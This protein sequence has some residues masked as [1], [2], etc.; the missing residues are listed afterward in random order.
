M[1]GKSTVSHLNAAGVYGEAAGTGTGVYGTSVYT[2]VYGVST[3]TSNGSGG[4]FVSKGDFGSGI[5]GISEGAN[6]YGVRGDGGDADFYA[7]GPGTNYAAASSVRWKSNIVEIDG[8]L[9]MV[10]NMRGV[11]Y[12]WDEEHGG[13]H[14]MGFIAEEVGE[15]VPEIV[16]FE[17]DGVY[18]NAVDYGAITPILLQAI[19]EQQVQIVALKEIVCRD[20]PGEEICQ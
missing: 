2:G 9:G 3:G 17:P 20:H 4:M 10:M 1:Y 14:D 13:S 16:A 19:K 11:Y 18:A 8:A 15:V 12:D 5:I 7:V 6:G